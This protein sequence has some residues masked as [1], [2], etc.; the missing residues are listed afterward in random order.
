MKIGEDKEVAFGGHHVTK[1]F[2]DDTSRLE[3]GVD[4]E[5]VDDDAGGKSRQK[6]VVLRWIA[7]QEK[8]AVRRATRTFSQDDMRSERRKYLRRV[9]TSSSRVLKLAWC[10]FALYWL[11]CC[12]LII[13]YGVLIYRYMGAGEEGAYITTWGMTFLLVN[14]GL[15]SLVI[16]GRK[17]FY[18]TFYNTWRKMFTPHFELNAWYEAYLERVGGVLLERNADGSKAAAAIAPRGAS[19][20]VAPAPP[21]HL[22]PPHTDQGNDDDSFVPIDPTMKTRWKAAMTSARA[23]ANLNVAM[24]FASLSRERMRRT[25]EAA[26]VQHATTLRLLHGVEVNDADVD[27]ATIVQDDLLEMVAESHR[28]LE[29]MKVIEGNIEG[30]REEARKKLLKRL[31]SKQAD[32]N[33][34]GDDGD[35]GEERRAPV[36]DD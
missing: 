6:E 18:K 12:Y 5:H 9:K 36:A 15:L 23:H 8:D 24:D 3:E 20:K 17:A 19:A 33:G 22:L 32:E 13:V 31:G 1:P 29:R 2:K 35:D 4:R 26:E 10:L 16:V 11:V 30:E 28:A 7:S 14:F 27:T 21:P 25:I 34:D